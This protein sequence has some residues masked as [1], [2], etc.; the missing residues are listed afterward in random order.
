MDCNHHV[1][2]SVQSPVK[3]EESVGPPA[4]EYMFFE[5]TD[6]NGDEILPVEQRLMNHLLRNY[7]R[8][9]ATREKC[10]RYRVRADGTH[11]NPDFWYGK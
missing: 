1:K 10:I 3:A 9:S 7:E 2:K 8:I 5:D 4:D 11:I 6:N